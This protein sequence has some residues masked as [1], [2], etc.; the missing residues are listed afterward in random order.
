LDD[1]RRAQDTTGGGRTAGI[2]CNQF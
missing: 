2:D 1:A